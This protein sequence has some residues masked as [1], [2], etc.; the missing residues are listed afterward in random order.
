MDDQG[1][2]RKP[3]SISPAD[4]AF[5][6]KM[7]MFQAIP[8]KAR[9]ELFSSVKRMSVRSGKRVISQGEPGD[10]FFIIREG[11][12]SVNLEKEDTLYRL[13][14]LGPGDILGEM[15]ILTGEKRNSHVDAQTDM[16]LWC[17]SKADFERIC[18]EHRELR[19]FLTGILTKRLDQS[20]LSPIRTIGKYILQEVIGRG[21][22]AIVY[23]G[24]HSSLG[25]PVAVKMLRH[26]LAMD[27]SFQNQFERE[28]KII[29]NL[30]HENIV[31]VYDIERL[32]RTVFIMMEFIEG[33]SLSRV[34]VEKGKLSSTES[35]AI[36]FQV[37]DALAY[38][39]K[40]EIVH[41]DIKPGNIM[42]QEGLKV[43]ILDFGLA[44]PPG[45]L[46]N[47]GLHGT[48]LYMAPEIIR[49]EEVD[50][51]ADIYALGILCYRMITGHNAFSGTE[52]VELFNQHLYGSVPDPREWVP[53]L[54]HQ[55]CDFLRRA[56]EKN[57]VARYQNAREIIEDLL[58]LAK[59][60]GVHHGTD[61][62]LSRSHTTTLFVSYRDEHEIIVKGLLREIG[63]EL[64][65]IGV[66]VR[67][68][69]LKDVEYD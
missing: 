56:T 61:Q 67:G 7:P 20:N 58:P 18:Q 29:A 64:E 48:P 55:L 24:T 11:S 19:H 3:R 4:F 26:T 62:S 38:A 16:T 23:K 22:W 15:A 57:P 54:P 35:L 27:P 41:R 42:I 32:Y 68:A 65:K 2:D 34:L 59:E 8:Q 45:V 1:S 6:K 37:C 51:R 47:P 14:V 31:K 30:N 28:A 12:C 60:L 66:V 40:R 49:G 46:T 9:L 5:V 21:G 33:V 10:S 25:L 36:L 44:R 13:A 17:V 39:H 69:D 53:D 52:P 43:K 63:K 50:E